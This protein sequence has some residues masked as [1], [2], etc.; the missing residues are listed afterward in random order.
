MTAATAARLLVGEQIVRLSAA[1][2]TSATCFHNLRSVQVIWRGFK[3][4]TQIGWP[5]R[6]VIVQFP[7]VP[8]IVAFIAGETGK[9]THGSSHAYASAVSYLA[10]VIWAYLELVEG[11]NWFRRLLGLAYVISTTVHLALA[12]QS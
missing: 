7:N 8:L 11:V 1:V 3:R 5:R 2:S 9:H 6:F 12:L 4:L 10:F